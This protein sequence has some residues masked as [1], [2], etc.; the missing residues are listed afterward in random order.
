MSKRLISAAA[1]GLTASLIIGGSA[2]AASTKPNHPPI[3]RTN[4]AVAYHLGTGSRKNTSRP[5]GQLVTGTVSSVSGS[6]ITLTAKNGGSYAIN[7]ASAKI[8]KTGAATDVSAILPGD[9]LMAR[10]TLSGLSMTATTIVDGVMQRPANGTQPT[11]SG[12]TSQ[13]TRDHNL[14]TPRLMG[15]ISTINGTS[16][17]LTLHAQSGQT[18]TS[19]TVLTNDSTIVTKDRVAATFAD[20]TT[21]ENVMI[22]G[23]KDATTGDFTANKISISTHALGAQAKS[24]LGRNHKKTSGTPTP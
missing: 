11:T 2:M 24:G 10:G 9:L 16:L 12:T 21:G 6:V 13:S 5:G 15:T 7:A 20:L 4:S 22:T 1:I 18:A 8:M 23:T 17:T 14:G 19:Q 3:Q